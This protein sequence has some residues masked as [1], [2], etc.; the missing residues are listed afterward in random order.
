MNLATKNLVW[1]RQD[2]HLLKA[3]KSRGADDENE[4]NVRN[5]NCF[6]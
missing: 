5:F 1:M 4:G 6:I 3:L 2:A